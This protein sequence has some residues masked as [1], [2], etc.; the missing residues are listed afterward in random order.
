MESIEE[1]LAR[2]RAT[3]GAILIDPRDAEDYA[4]GFIPGAVNI[5]PERIREAVA[6]IAEPDTPI[7]LC[8][9]SGM[10]S[11]QAEALLQAMG[12]QNVQSIGGMDRYRGELAERD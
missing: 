7:Y 6:E 1:G 11:W 3:D 4:A 12:Y 10:R 5:P 2:W 8:C 9:Y